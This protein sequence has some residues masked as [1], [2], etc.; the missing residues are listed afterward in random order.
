V[1]R[2]THI[3]PLEARSGR[4]FWLFGWYLRFLFWR[5]FDAVRVSH[6]GEP[7]P[8]VTAGVS[9]PVIVYSN[10]P[11]WWDPTLYMLL[12]AIV[13]RRYASFGPMQAKA[14]GK[15]AFF[16]KLGVFPI[17]PTTRAGAAEFLNVARR[18]LSSPNGMLWVTAEG[19]FVDPRVR[20][21]SLRAGVAHLARSVPNAVMVPLAIEYGFWN[22]SHPGVFL[23]FGTPL[24][25][26]RHLD[27]SEWHARLERELT[28]A[29]DGLAQETMTR[30][31]ALFRSLLRG[32]AGLGGIYDWYR[33]ARGLLRGTWFDTSHEGFRR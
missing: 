14:L 3:D 26:G 17:D 11:S 30:D 8:S 18:V 22:E 32:A 25:T 23:R 24:P 16:R 5:K 9:G 27:V 1:T 29:M 15:Y 13:F 4:L 20:P 6:S 12:A 2:A 10:H 19:A 33:R 28:A 31:P 21:V 7:P